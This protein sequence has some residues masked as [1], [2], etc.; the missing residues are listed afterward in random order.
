[1]IFRKYV[2]SLMR[3]DS[4]SYSVVIFNV[5]EMHVVLY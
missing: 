1:M 3:E 4:A 2:D 5:Y